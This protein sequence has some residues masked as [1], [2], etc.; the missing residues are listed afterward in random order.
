MM[1]FVA[2]FTGFILTIRIVCEIGCLHVPVRK[3][4]V[5]ITLLPV[6]S[7]AGVLFYYLFARDRMARW[8]APR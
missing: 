7:W 6:T 1:V 8:L 3:R 5:F 4:L 2:W